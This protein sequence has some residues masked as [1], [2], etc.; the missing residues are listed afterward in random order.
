M[1]YDNAAHAEGKTFTVVETW[2]KRGH[3]YK[4]LFCIC[5]GFR[6]PAA[7]SPGCLTTVIKPHRAWILMLH[8][9]PPV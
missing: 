5:D 2:Y 3:E 4:F 6:V 7:I 8:F 1:H 9:Q